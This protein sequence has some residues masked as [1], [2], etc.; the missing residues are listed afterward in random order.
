MTDTPRKDG[1]RTEACDRGEA[2]L[3][4]TTHGGALW[5]ALSHRCNGW[6]RAID[7][8]VAGRPLGHCACGEDIVHDDRLAWR[9]AD[10]LAGSGERLPK[11]AFATEAGD[12]LLARNAD[13]DRA[14]VEW[15]TNDIRAIEQE[16]FDKV[17]VALAA[18][19]T[20]APRDVAGSG[21]PPEGTRLVLVSDGLFEALGATSVDW[22]EPDE[23]GWYTPTL[24]RA[25]PTTQAP[26]EETPG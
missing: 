25:T 18:P 9:A 2:G 1:P 12:R 26:R 24:Y 6:Q 16:E 10:D 3:R 22:G 7:T 8:I 5:P 21:G 19:I 13:R 23:H 20:Q 11:R 15:L 4:C 14:V 17:L